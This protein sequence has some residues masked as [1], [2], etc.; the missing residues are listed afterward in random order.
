[1]GV[2]Q[3]ERISLRGSVSTRPL[4]VPLTTVVSALIVICTLALWCVSMQWVNVGAMNDLGLASVLP[5]SSFIALGGLTL[6]FCLILNSLEGSSH[7]VLL[8]YLL[9]LIFML[10]A[11]PA[12]V[13]Q[14]PRFDVTYWLAGHTEYVLRNG[15]VDPYFD[16]YF[17]WPGFFV[18]TGL[19][20]KIS[21]VSSVLAFAPWASFVYN[22]LYLVPMYLI[23]TAFTQDR[24]T[25]WLGLWFFYITDWVWQDYFD[26]QGLNFFFYLVIIAILLKAFQ[27][28]RGYIGQRRGFCCHVAAVLLTL[29]AQS[30]CRHRAA[31]DG[32]LVG[33]DAGQSHPTRAGVGQ[34]RRTLGVCESFPTMGSA[35][36]RR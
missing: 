22:L 9:A 6:G 28:T 12:L 32:T 31:R 17:N 4:A 3:S 29:C 1:M 11:T 18:L 14:A 27:T 30:A 16:A 8:L 2:R 33:L 15:T 34:L 26:P 10:Y 23:F 24:R 13:E 7:V 19:L 36:R 20:T 35:F 21:G 25:V 5:V